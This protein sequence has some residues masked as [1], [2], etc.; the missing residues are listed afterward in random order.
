MHKDNHVKC[1]LNI[2]VYIPIKYI[3]SNIELFSSWTNAL[4]L[5]LPYITNNG[6]LLSI[7]GQNEMNLLK[8][9]HF[10]TVTISSTRRER[11]DI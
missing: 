11:N 4:P 2:D 7:S 8:Y 10:S 6:A 1:Q 9:V 5:Y 3:N